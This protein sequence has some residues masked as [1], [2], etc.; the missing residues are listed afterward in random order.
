MTTTLP[1]RVSSEPEQAVLAFRSLNEVESIDDK[2]KKIMSELPHLSGEA[3][4]LLETSI[5]LQ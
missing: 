3:H 2:L 5:L 4:H 1:D